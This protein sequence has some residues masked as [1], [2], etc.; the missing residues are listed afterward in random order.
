MEDTFV[1]HG[2]AGMLLEQQLP[3][4]LSKAPA[5][6]DNV[7]SSTLVHR[8]ILVAYVVEDI[9]R[10][11]AVAGADF[12]DDEVFV[13]VVFQEV[14]GRKA[15]CY[16]LP[17]PRLTNTVSFQQSILAPRKLSATHLEQLRWRVPYLSTWPLLL[18]LELFIPSRHFI[19][20]L[21]SIAHL[22]KVDWFR[23][24][25]D[26]GLLREIAIVRVVQRIFYEVSHQH[27]DF[28]GRCAETFQVIRSDSLI[29]NMG[30]VRRVR[31][32]DRIVVDLDG[33]LLGLLPRGDRCRERVVKPSTVRAHA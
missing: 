6:L 1:R 26:G 18:R 3:L 12:V 27:L 30:Y 15:S 22:T 10:Q 7:I 33:W 13:R 25:K 23:C 9:A 5:N 20:E 21:Y 28:S 16:C 24:S 29:V 4:Q 8:R 2:D 32:R 14:F 19:L 31:K 11:S 17:V